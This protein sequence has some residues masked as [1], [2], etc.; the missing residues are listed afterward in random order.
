MAIQIR[1][2]ENSNLTIAEQIQQQIELAIA[3]G[4]LKQ[5]DALPS[6]RAL[7]MQ[8]KVNPNTIA[9]SLQN[10]VHGGSLISQKGRGYFVAPP[11]AI[12][13]QQEIDR[14]L[15]AAAKRFVAETR[16]LGLSYGQ[17]VAAISKLLPEGD[18]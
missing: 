16:C 12:L 10:M 13:S 8:L 18:K 14:R 2:L 11:T 1:L 4:V 7:A 5:G 6:V 3:Q 17:L 9:R 15:G